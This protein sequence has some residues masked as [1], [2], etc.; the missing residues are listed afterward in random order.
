MHAKDPDYQPTLPSDDT[1]ART[2]VRP[3]LSHGIFVIVGSPTSKAESAT[4]REGDFS[5]K[6]K[7]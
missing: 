6:A 3:L 7:R 1:S 2:G 4:T 5:W